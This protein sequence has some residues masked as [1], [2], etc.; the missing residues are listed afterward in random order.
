MAELQS[1]VIFCEKR[2][3]GYLYFVKYKYQ[4]SGGNIMDRIE[5]KRNA[6]QTLSGNWQWAVIL[7]LLTS[8]ISGG[9]GGVTWGIGYFIA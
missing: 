4:N 8:I 6:K 3:R 9:I 5:L 7:T 1:S 2:C